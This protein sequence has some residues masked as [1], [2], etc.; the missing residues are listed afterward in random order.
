[1]ET[2]KLEDQSNYR[3]SEISKVKYYFNEEILY[4]QSLTNKLSKYLTVFDY[5][6]KIL[7]VALTVFSSTNIFVH[8]KGKKKLVGLI[9]S[10]FSLLFSLSF[11]IVIKLKQ[12]TKLR[13]KK[14]NGLLYLAKNKLDFIEMLISDFI[15]D[16]IINHDE[17]LE[18]LKEKKEYDSL[19]NE[20]KVVV[21]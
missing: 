13:K 4:Q 7:T 10:I 9:T 21:V 14:H 2:I 19:K 1:M 8:V 18:I 11:G 20:D 6:N 16:G 3:L 17:F 12:E 15:E 5:L